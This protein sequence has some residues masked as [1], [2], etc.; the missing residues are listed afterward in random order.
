MNLILFG[1]PGTGKGTQ[2]EFLQAE[3]GLT[4]IATGDLFRDHL[5]KLHPAGFSGAGVHEPRATCPG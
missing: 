4:H 2:A 1:A 3:L 5:K